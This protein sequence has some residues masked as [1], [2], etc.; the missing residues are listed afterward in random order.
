MGTLSI[1]LPEELERS[2]GEF[3]VDWSD[4]ARR[5][6]IEESE[7]LKRLKVFSSK[8]KL[9]DD[10]ASELS[11]RLNSAVARGFLKEAT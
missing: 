5:A 8:F 6:L 10:D 1:D 7:R 11:A 2:M 9:S 3:K 4:V